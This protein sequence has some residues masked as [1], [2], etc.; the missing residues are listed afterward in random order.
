MIRQIY[1]ENDRIASIIR[2][3][4]TGTPVTDTE[5]IAV[6][7]D[8]ISPVCDSFETAQLLIDRYGSMAGVCAAPYDEL[9][10]IEGVKRKGARLLKVC[11]AAVSNILSENSSDERCRLYTQ[12]ELVDYLCPYFV[13]EKVEK[14]YL[15]SLSAKY[16]VLGLKL[17]AKGDSDSLIFDKKLL[18]EEALKRGASSVVLAHNHFISA[19]PSAQDVILTNDICGLLQRMGIKLHDHLIFCENKAK[20]MR[21]SGYIKSESS[22]IF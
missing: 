9:A 8:G 2:M 16:R 21:K 14:L 6:L 3:I 19:L 15:L 7:L 20:S 4:D 1:G 13:N 11:G 10:G 18:I 22:L 17:I 5:L 12:D